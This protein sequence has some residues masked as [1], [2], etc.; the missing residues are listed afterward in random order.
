MAD[1]YKV[2]YF[3]MAGMSIATLVGVGLFFGWMLWG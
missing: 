2:G 1:V 3:L